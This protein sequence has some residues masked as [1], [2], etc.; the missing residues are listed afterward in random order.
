[1]GRIQSDEH[2]HNAHERQQR[3]ERQPRS[4][5]VRVVRCQERVANPTDFPVFAVF[6]NSRPGQNRTEDNWHTGR[7]IAALAC[8]SRYRSL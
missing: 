7:Q 8:F 3:E 4:L 6:F 5:P 2:D 1:M